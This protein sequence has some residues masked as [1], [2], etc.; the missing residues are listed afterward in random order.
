MRGRHTH[1]SIAGTLALR[2]F[3]YVCFHPKVYSEGEDRRMASELLKECRKELIRYLSLLLR[4]QEQPS[5]MHQVTSVTL[6]Y[7]PFFF[8]FVF[9]SIIFSQILVLAIFFQQGPKEFGLQVMGLFLAI[10][11]L[12]L[13]LDG[14]R[15]SVMPLAEVIGEELPKTLA[16]PFVLLIAF[17]LGILVTYAEPAIAALRPLATLV[18]PNRAPYLYFIMNKQ[19]EL[20]VFA[21]GAGV[22]VAAVIG[23]L[24]F[25]KDWPLK[26][27]IFSALIPT[28]SCAIYMQWGNE[29]LVPLIGMAW[30]CGAVTTGKVFLSILEDVRP[31]STCFFFF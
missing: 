20:M 3:R 26:P 15:V 10:I 18:D 12:V 21:I 25:I 5:S 2:A 1:Q 16:L 6:T 31:C 13:F 14:L 19:Q 28:V 4:P 30:D 8:Y 17:F 23:T 22:G 24:R 11:G 7:W 9:L 27:L 29:N